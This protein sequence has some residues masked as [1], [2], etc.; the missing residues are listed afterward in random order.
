MASRHVN[1]ELGEL[2]GIAGTFAFADG[3]GN[4]DDTGESGRLRAVNFKL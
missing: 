4:Y 2:I 1:D 3:H